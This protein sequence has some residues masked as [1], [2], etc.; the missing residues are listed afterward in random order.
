MSPTTVAG[1][2]LECASGRMSEAPMYNKNP[3]KN[4][5][6]SVRTEGG[7]RNNKVDAA[8]KTG[9]IASNTSIAN[10]RRVVLR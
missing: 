7:A 9:A 10:E 5:I 1:R 3:A 2:A 4:P 6:K 8:P